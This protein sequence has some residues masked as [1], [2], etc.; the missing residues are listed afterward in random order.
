MRHA[1]GLTLIEVLISLAILAIA[2]LAVVMSYNDSLR[3]TRYLVQKTYASWIGMDLIARAEIG[4]VQAPMFPQQLKGN[5][6]AFKQS[7]TWEITQKPTPDPH[8]FLLIATLHE[9]SGQQLLVLNGY[10]SQWS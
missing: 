2:F 7:W 9:S 10:R 5:L 6:Q 4:I 3:S 8:T 1:R